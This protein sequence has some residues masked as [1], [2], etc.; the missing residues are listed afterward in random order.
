MGVDPTAICVFALASGGGKFGLSVNE[1]QCFGMERG[2]LVIVILVEMTGDRVW[3]PHT[4]IAETFSLFRIR[5][6]RV[7]SICFLC[8]VQV[9][10]YATWFRS[11]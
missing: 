10:T 4:V 9:N 7:A 6:Y 8:S 2:F 3:S 1:A 5:V 11:N